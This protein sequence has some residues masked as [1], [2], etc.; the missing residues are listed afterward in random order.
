MFPHLSEHDCGQAAM[1]R[2]AVNAVLH[3][4][5]AKTCKSGCPRSL[6][7]SRRSSRPLK[8]R[9]LPH[10]AHQ[11]DREPMSHR[12]G[13]SEESRKLRISNEG[14]PISRFSDI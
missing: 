5:R 12:M 1:S 2:A 8:R 9:D 7:G 10:P 14:R 6:A 13:L 11:S 4:L 3:A